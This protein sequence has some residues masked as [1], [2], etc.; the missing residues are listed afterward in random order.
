MEDMKRYVLLHAHTKDREEGRKG[1]LTDTS[2][3]ELGEKEAE[4]L[5]PTLKKNTYDIFFV[6]S[7]RRTADT[8]T[9]FLGTLINPEVI[10]NDLTIE[11][12]LGLLTNTTREQFKTYLKDHEVVDRISWQP[13]KGESILQVQ[14][15]AKKFLEYL[16]N[17][18]ADKTVLVCG[19][20]VFLRCLELLIIGK[21][22][23]EFYSENPPRL[24]PAELRYYEVK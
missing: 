13:P 10:I 1:S 20:K 5:V 15:R 21:P 14:E 8:L 24:Q 4:D 17:N 18:F 7:L 12:D 6:S 2:L 9:P 16:K 11:R 22:I 3:S 23:G 19:H